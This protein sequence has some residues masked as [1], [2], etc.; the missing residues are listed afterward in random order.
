MIFSDYLPLRRH[1]TA[2]FR[3]DPGCLGGLVTPPISGVLAALA[4]RGVHAAVTPR[5]PQWSE[6]P[7][8]ETLRRI[9]V[10]KWNK[11][12]RAVDPATVTGAYHSEVRLPTGI[13]LGVGSEIATLPSGECVAKEDAVIVMSVPMNR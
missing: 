2:A 5:D 13:I 1:R 8:A 9:P 12:C 10:H 11:V 7:P 6:P 3:L 4:Q